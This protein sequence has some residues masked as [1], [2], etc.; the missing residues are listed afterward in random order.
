MTPG[1]RRL[2]AASGA[3]VRKCLPER[4]ASTGLPRS[5][6][7]Q[8]KG[9]GG[10]AP[11]PC[12]FHSSLVH[13]P[14]ESPSCDVP[15]CHPCQPVSFPRPESDT[16]TSVGWGKRTKISLCSLF[17]LQCS[18]APHA[19]QLFGTLPAL[20]LHLPAYRTHGRCLTRPGRKRAVVR[21]LYSQRSSSSR[22][23]TTICWAAA[24]GS[25][26]VVSIWKRCNTYCTRAPRLATARCP[27]RMP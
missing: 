21:Y 14:G 12:S 24:L 15:G 22:L 11:P 7:R 20:G 4:A 6:C 8:N 2:G 3:A 5:F 16:N 13:H 1:L 18:K 9:G 19:F 25:I 23:A 26:L 27:S 10:W 17:M